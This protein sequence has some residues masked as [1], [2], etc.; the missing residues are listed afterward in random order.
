MSDD[1]DRLLDGSPV[2][3]HSE[4][5][6]EKSARIIDRNRSLVWLVI[7]YIVMRMAVLTFSGR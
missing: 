6:L 3:A 2:T 5:L 1:V 4:S 7:A